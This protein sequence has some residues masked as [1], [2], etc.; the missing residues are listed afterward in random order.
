MNAYLLEL[1]TGKGKRAAIL[2]TDCR[3][4]GGYGRHPIAGNLIR[5]D[6]PSLCRFE[7]CSF[8]RVAV[9]DLD[10]LQGAFVQCTMTELLSQPRPTSQMTLE[11]CRVDVLTAQRARDIEWLRR[12]L[13]ELFPQWREQLNR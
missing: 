13:N 6:G 10:D 8:S 5:A 4:E 3:F 9:Q 1:G 7:R 12:D 2:A 11:G